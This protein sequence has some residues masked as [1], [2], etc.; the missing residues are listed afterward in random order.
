MFSPDGNA[1]LFSPE[2]SGADSLRGFFHS[3]A[4]PE[5]APNPNGYHAR[6]EEEEGKWQ[7]KKANLGNRKTK[8][9]PDRSPAGLF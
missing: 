8:K 7:K 9:N 5:R 3:S 4:G 1:A 6:T 2:Q